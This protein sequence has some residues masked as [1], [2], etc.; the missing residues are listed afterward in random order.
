MN[1]VLLTILA[2]SAMALAGC[3]TAR[4]P[5]TVLQTPFGEFKGP[6][7]ME[8]EIEGLQYQRDTNGIIFLT[9]KSI[10]S[11]TKNNPAVIGAS[12]DQDEVRWK[13]LKDLVGEAVE[14]GIK[15]GKTL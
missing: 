1:K 4:V 15:A 10:R 14:R 9:A 13:G 6:K 11:K 7:D 5:Q 8:L 12:A 3:Q 2:V